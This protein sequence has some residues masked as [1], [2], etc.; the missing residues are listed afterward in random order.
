MSCLYLEKENN[1][2]KKKFFFAKLTKLQAPMR[3][4]KNSNQT[5][6][7]YFKLIGHL[8]ETLN[9]I[10]TKIFVRMVF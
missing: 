10:K 4:L 1:K 5:T 7:P 8:K 3:D 9:A 6:Q 2:H